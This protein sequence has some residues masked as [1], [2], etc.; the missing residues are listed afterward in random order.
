MIGHCSG[1]GVGQHI[2]GQH[3]GRE[4][5]L[6]VMSSLKSALTLLNGYFRKITDCVSKMMRCG[7]VQRIL[8]AHNKITS[9]FLALLP[10]VFWRYPG[11]Q[12]RIFRFR[13]CLADSTFLF[14]CFLFFLVCL[15]AGERLPQSRR[16]RPWEVLQ[17]PQRSVPGSC[18]HRRRWRKP[19]SSRRNC[20]C[21]SGRR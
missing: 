5:E 14:C 4:C 19:R 2:N 3:A 21:R 11:R 12:S 17:P 9:I 1:T 6:V 20:S 10:F 7:Y 15:T 8:L 16:E 13:L 18:L